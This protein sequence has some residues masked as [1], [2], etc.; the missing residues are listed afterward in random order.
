MTE[1]ELAR[2]LME[3]LEQIMDQLAQLADLQSECADSV[4]RIAHSVAVKPDDSGKAARERTQSEKWRQDWLARRAGQLANRL[5]GV[6]DDYAISRI[7]QASR[8]R[9]LRETANGLARLSGADMP[10]VVVALSEALSVLRGESPTTQ[11]GEDR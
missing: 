4:T 1:P 10:G 9:R 3:Q 2:L 5:S 11:P 6:A 7:G 8:R